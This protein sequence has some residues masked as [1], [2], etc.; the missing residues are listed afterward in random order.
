MQAWATWFKS[1][2]FQTF[3]QATVHSGNFRPALSRWGV[4][5]TEWIYVTSQD[6]FWVHLHSILGC[7]GL[8]RASAYTKPAPSQ[9]SLLQVPVKVACPLCISFSMCQIGIQW[10]PFPTLFLPFPGGIFKL[11]QLALVKY[12]VVLWWLTPWKCLSLVLRFHLFAAW[13]NLS[14]EVLTQE[15]L[16]LLCPK[17]SKVYFLNL[18][19]KHRRDS[20]ICFILSFM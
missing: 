3:T 14:N 4:C 6:L 11:H 2:T 13:Y 8:K 17:L 20:K 19:I 16:N 7:E 5:L 15:I 12:T 9:S 18:W 1:D 10:S